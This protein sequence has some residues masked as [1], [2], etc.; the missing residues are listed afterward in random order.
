MYMYEL[1]RTYTYIYIHTNWRRENG[2]VV[3]R[4]PG[5]EGRLVQNYGAIRHPA[6]FFCTKVTSQQPSAT[7]AARH[8]CIYRP[9]DTTTHP[10]PL[11]TYSPPGRDLYTAVSEIASRCHEVKGDY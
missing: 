11:C 5:G 9:A 7:A 10:T 3:G 2:A 4:D 6:S 8:A 1:M